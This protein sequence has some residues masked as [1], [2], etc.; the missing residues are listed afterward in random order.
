MMGWKGIVVIDPSIKDRKC[1]CIPLSMVKLPQLPDVIDH[2][3]F[4]I[5]GYSHPMPPARLNINL[6][7]QLWCYCPSPESPLRQY[8]IKL[9]DIWLKKISDTLQPADIF[10]D[11]IGH[12]NR[13]NCGSFCGADVPLYCLRVR[14]AMEVGDWDGVCQALAGLP[15]TGLI[16]ASSLWLELQA[17][18]I[19]VPN[20]RVLYGVMDPLKILKPGKVFIRITS[21]PDGST[22]AI[23]RFVVI[24]K[25]E[26][27]HRFW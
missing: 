20:S 21:I 16:A 24:A 12:G 1:I 15:T 9:T 19:P 10:N 11:T 26:R 5:V 17:L 18:S 2:I 7:H 4:S 23:K 27:R 22:A 13:I 6:L 14:S 3:M 25:D 8:I